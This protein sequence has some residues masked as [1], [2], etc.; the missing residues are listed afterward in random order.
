M[1]VDAGRTEPGALRQLRVLERGPEAM[2]GVPRADEH[3]SRTASPSRAK[4]R[5]R[6]GWGLTVYSSALPV[7]L[8][9]VRH[10]GE[11]AREDR[12][13]HDQMVG[14]REVRPHTRGHLAHGG[15]VRVEVAPELRFVALCERAG[16]DALVDVGHVHG[17]QATDIG[18]INRAARVRAEFADTQLALLPVSDCVDKGLALGMAVL[19]EQV[20]LVPELDERGGGPS[21]AL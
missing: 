21:R 14:E 15:D 16:F 3:R 18:P 2:R 12:G 5:K 20:H 11:G 10:V 19:T 7:N 8:D 4:G 17:Q 9:G 6:S 1:H 13:A